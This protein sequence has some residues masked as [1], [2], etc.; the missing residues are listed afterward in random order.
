MPEG[1]TLH[2]LANALRPALVG[3]AITGAWSHAWGPLDALKG[4]E[5]TSVEAVGKHLLIAFAR[6]GALRVH[7]GMRGVWHAYHR[8][9]PWKRSPEAASLWLETARFTFVCFHASQVEWSTSSSS[10][11][12]ALHLGP[13][14]LAAE[15]DFSLILARLRRCDPKRSIGEVLLDQRIASGIGN[16]YKSELLFLEGLHPWTPL[17]RIDETKLKAIYGL[18]RKLLQRN[19]AMG[20]RRRTVFGALGG[21][22]GARLW[23]YNRVGKAC[24]R[25]GTSVATRRQGDQARSTFWCPS[26]QAEAPETLSASGANP[27][28]SS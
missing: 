10:Q 14:L 25:C 26:C 20:G 24:L 11:R 7:L 6:E 17:G 1:D 13:D 3:E 18:A 21:P 19:V 8:G 5:V 22:G 2:R 23:V 12:R 28:P 4:E 27:L 9:G 16:V 15:Y